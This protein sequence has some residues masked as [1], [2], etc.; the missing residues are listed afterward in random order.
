MSSLGLTL[1]PRP[2]PQ[3]REV[4]DVGEARNCLAIAERS[5][6]NNKVGVLRFQ[7]RRRVICECFFA[8]SVCLAKG[9]R[10]H[11]WRIRLVAFLRRLTSAGF[12]P[13][14]LNHNEVIRVSF[15]GN[16]LSSAVE[17][18]Q[19]LP[20]PEERAHVGVAADHFSPAAAV[21]FAVSVEPCTRFHMSS[22]KKTSI[23]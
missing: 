11:R 8:L 22:W 15:W 3:T 12:W 10:E 9:A 23:P 2:P 16:N 7:E 4:A 21:Y 1:P 17:G 14:A 5:K 13:L 6:R 19:C 18:K 20:S